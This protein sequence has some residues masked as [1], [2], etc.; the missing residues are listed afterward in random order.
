MN[1]Y[2]IGLAIY[3]PAERIMN[4]R[5]EEMVYTTTRAALDDAG[6]TRGELDNVVLAASDEFDGRSIS[7]MLMAMPAGAYLTDEI[8]VTDAGAMGLCLAAARIASGDFHLGVV[9]SWCKSSKTDVEGLMRLKGEPFFTRPLGLN[10][11][12]TDALFGRAVVERWGIGPEEINDRVLAAYQRAAGNPRGV[13]HRVPSPAEVADSDYVSAPL[14]QGHRAPMTDG[15]VSLVLASEEWVDAHPER[16]PLARLSG[17]G[18]ATDG[19][20]LG[21]E[22]L[23]GMHSARIA[24]DMALK[25]AGLGSASEV[26][27]VEIES[28]TGFHEAAYVRAFELEGHPGLSP[29]G[30]PFAQNP[31]FCSGLVNMAEAVLQVSGRAG[32]VQVQGAR[33]GV[34]HGCHGF[35]QQANIVAVFESVEA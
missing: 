5:L 18:W 23:G 25:R 3:P 21:R 35:A 6:V 2:V 20:Q 13:R 15:A 19:Y 33:R 14:R 16:E 31:Y 27:V 1:I 24:W 12:V 4:E 32:P 28:Q 30:G 7:S 29:S 17:V 9:A 8:K 34:G 26:E 11:A 10:C 22:R